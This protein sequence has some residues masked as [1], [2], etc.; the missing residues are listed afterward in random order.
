MRGMNL[1]RLKSFFTFD[2]P[3][4]AGY[5]RLSLHTIHK[6]QILCFPS[7]NIESTRR[8]IIADYWY[9]HVLYHFSS[10]FTLAL[11]IVLPFNLYFSLLY[12][13]ILIMYGSI[14]FSVILLCV[15]LPQFM[16]KFLPQLEALIAHYKSIQPVIRQEKC[17]K[18]QP[19]IPALTVIHYI[20]LQTAGVKTIACDQRSAQLINMLTGVDTGSIKE[21]L[22]RISYPGSLSPKERTEVL[23]GIT[24]ARSFFG[25]LGYHPAFKI[26]DKLEMKLQGV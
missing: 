6:H 7:W 3:F 1:K 24:V 23:K 8:K 26:L 16:S 21:N 10:L 2:L 22:R 20:L 19:K 15:Y 17:A 14:A 11:L 9:R 5:N 12:L 4:N 25:K 18:T 13:S